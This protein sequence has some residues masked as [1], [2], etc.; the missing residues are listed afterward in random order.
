MSG[1]RAVKPFRRIL[2]P[3]DF[4]TA[5]RA[6]FGEA[7]AL[8]GRGGARLSILHVLVPPSPFV[9]AEGAETPTYLDL[10]AASRRAAREGLGKALARVRR[11]GVRGRTELV[12]GIPFEA[13]ARAARRERA[14]V[15]V[16]GTH[17]RTGLRRLLMGSVTAR[18]LATAP[19][20]VITV[21]GR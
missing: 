6:A 3:T 20:P 11:A 5:G 17:G 15:I 12:E 19:C 2:H 13:I 16:M 21:R 14:D 1:R 10:E 4:S 8:A 9:H 7:L 18:V